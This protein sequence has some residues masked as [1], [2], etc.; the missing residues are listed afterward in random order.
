MGLSTTV[1]TGKEGERN[2]HL[3]FV[4]VPGT[5]PHAVSTPCLVF[6][7]YPLEVN[8]LSQAWFPLRRCWGGPRGVRSL[9]RI[10]N[11]NGK[12]ENAKVGRRSWTRMQ[13]QPSLDGG[14]WCGCSWSVSC[15]RQKWPC[16]L[17]S[18][19]SVS[20]CELLR[21]GHGLG[22]SSLLTT[23]PVGG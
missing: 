15:S 7:Q 12:R 4:N 14:L 17:A 9:L 23:H 10:N 8:Y 3:C 13:A 22:W 5:M 1:S 6:T 16:L 2:R 19:Y 20:R 11:C 21:E 18:P